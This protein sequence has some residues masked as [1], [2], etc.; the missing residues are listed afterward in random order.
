V[1]TIGTTSEGDLHLHK[2]RCADTRRA[3]NDYRS[4]VEDHETPASVQAFVED[5]FSDHSTVQDG[6]WDLY[7]EDGQ[8][9]VMPCLRIPLTTPKR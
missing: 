3:G 2:H 5:Y 9:R 6:D 4:N 8:V 1:I 7:V